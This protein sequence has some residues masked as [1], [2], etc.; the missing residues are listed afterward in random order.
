[1]PV[2]LIVEDNDQSRTQLAKIFSKAGWDVR[3]ASGAT[4]ALAALDRPPECVV[5]DLVLPDGDGA[6]VLTR[7]RT[8]NIAVRVVAVVTGL[9]DPTRLSAVAALRPDLMIQ[10]PF[11]PDIIWRYCQSEVVRE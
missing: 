10:K 9:S 5:L 3:L 2:V 11:A 7:I 6:E 1:M 4:E 8:E